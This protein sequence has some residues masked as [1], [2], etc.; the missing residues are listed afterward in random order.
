MLHSS[1]LFTEFKGA[2]TEN[3]AAQMLNAAHVRG[4]YYWSSGNRAE[5]DF[6]IQLENEIYPLE[7][8]A[9]V[10]K[11]KKSLKVYSEKY[12]P[13]LL[14]RSSLMNLNFEGKILNVPLYLVERLPALVGLTGLE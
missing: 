1:E 4:L 11:R 5:V 8:K 3:L 14:L 13:T 10:S 7:V 6:I 2:L 9:G 12:N